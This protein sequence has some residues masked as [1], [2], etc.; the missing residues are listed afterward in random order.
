MEQTQDDGMDLEFTDGKDAEEASGEDIADS[1]ANSDDS[2]KEQEELF[3]L[4]RR[5][6]EIRKEVC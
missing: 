2:D 3:M 5:I 4:E 1:D 6:V